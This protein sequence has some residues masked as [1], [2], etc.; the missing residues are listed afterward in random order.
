MLKSVKTIDDLASLLG[1]GRKQL[2]YWAYVAPEAA[3]YIHFKLPKRT[4]GDRPIS[5]PS[6]TLLRIQKSIA[7]MLLDIYPTPSNVHGFVKA[8]SIVSGAENHVR[9]RWVIKID[10]EDFFGAINFGRIRG[11]LQAPPLGLPSEVATVVAQLC[12]HDNRLPQG[13]P[14]S[15]ILS[16]FVC[17]KLDSNLRALAR[18]HGCRVT[19]YADDITFSTSRKACPVDL[20][21]RIGTDFETRASAGKNLIDVIESN[22]F[23]VNASKTRVFSREHRQISTGLTVNAFPNVHRRYVRDLR[24]MIHAARK[25]GVDAAEVAFLNKFAKRKRHPKSGPPSFLRVLRGRI[26][27]LR[28]VRGRDDPLFIKFAKAARQIDSTLFPGSLGPMEQLES[29]LWVVEGDESQGTG[30]LLD[31]VGLVTC[32]HVLDKNFVAYQP[33]NSHTKIPVKVEKENAHLDL[34]ILSGSFPATAGKLKRGKTDA[35]HREQR[36][37]LTGYPGFS[38]GHREPFL[39]WGEISALR[40]FSTVEFMLITSI[41]SAGASG[42]PVLNEKFEVIGVARTGLDHP[43][44]SASKPTERHGAVIVSEL[45]K[46]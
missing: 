20:A 25:Y 40:T 41:I 13:A 27:Y 29:A 31:G 32:Q 39:Q 3:R 1:L 35:L 45:D 10:L 46:L 12:C 8:R 33:K 18:S 11:L 43:A 5:K 37:L 17:L 42:A 21:L 15:P 34:A 26:E 6:S 30:F 23:K 16:N 28:M 2:D 19:R 22:G 9:R 4:G 7:D 24:G 38:P 44:E 14:T 36:V